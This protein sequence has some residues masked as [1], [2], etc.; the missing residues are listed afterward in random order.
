MTKEIINKRVSQTIRLLLISLIA[1]LFS[2]SPARKLTKNQYLLKRNRIILKSKDNNLDKSK[3][4][5]YIKQKPNTRVLG[6]FPFYLRMY[7]ALNIGKER[8]WKNKLKEVIGEEPIIYDKYLTDKTKKQLL[9]Y[10]KNKGYYN[11]EISDTVK[12]RNKL[13]FVD[14]RII[15]GI[16]YIIKNIEYSISDSAIRKIIVAD[17]ASNTLLT[18]GRLFDVDV[19]EAE[20]IRI[21]NLLRNK[22]YYNFSK[23]FIDYLIDSTLA[24]KQVNINLRIKPFPFIDKQ[25]KKEFK[26]HEKF[27][28]RKVFVYLDLGQ[29]KLL[30]DSLN[31]EASPDTLVFRGVTF[32]FNNKL[33]IDPDVITAQIMLNTGDMYSSEK[34]NLTYRYLSG[35]QQ[36]KFINIQ[37]NPLPDSLP[38]DSCSALDCHIHLVRFTSKSY[39]VEFDGTNSATHWGLGGNLLFSNKNIFH[40]AQIFSLK[41]SGAIEVQHDIIGESNID[42]YLPNTLEMGLES[43]LKIPKFWTPFNTGFLRKYHPGTAISLMYNYQDRPDYTRTLI[44]AG[45]AYHW[46]SSENKKHIFSPFNL[47]IINLKDTTALFNQYFDTLF[48]KHSYESQFISSSNYMYEFSNQDKKRSRNFTYIKFRAEL[49]G[50]FINGM[51]KL[52]GSTKNDNNYYE[53]FNTRY[54]QYVRADIDTRFFQYL[55]KSS[56]LVYRGFIGVGK[57]YGNS[58]LLPFVKKYFAG[59]ANGIRAWQVRSLGP[60]SYIDNSNLPDLAA[61]IKLEANIEYR[62]D[63]IWKLKGAFFI[64]AGNIWAINNFDDREGAKF[65]IN[66]FYKE[67]AVGTGLGARFDFDFILFRIDLGIK[68]RDPELPIGNRLIWGSRKL[69]ASDYSWNV[70]IGYPF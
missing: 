60:G 39:Q 40:G 24:S 15:P 16:P 20:R 30:D 49:A 10:L 12:F 19:L 62:F 33:S 69:G 41:Y 67:I 27:K 63:V 17:S 8:K 36:F 9:L 54:A 47:N 58:E 53:L 26:N 46:K 37:Y 56:V 52:I 6:I 29:R 70:G 23:E 66:N 1:L 13:A 21:S 14:Y 64:D 28:I 2:C 43:S 32:I 34:S 57:P 4:E 45:Y 22:A 25:N 55:N 51:N 65:E 5:E 38:G 31:I 68:V 3:I 42:N 18:K 7:N 48:L 35:L 50:N 61:D 44:N 59:G 11:A